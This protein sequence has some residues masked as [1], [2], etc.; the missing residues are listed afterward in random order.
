MSLVSYLSR[1]GKDIIT[2]DVSSSRLTVLGGDVQ[3]TSEKAQSKHIPCQCKQ[4]THKHG[5]KSLVLT[6]C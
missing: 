2:C 3:M 4:E 6:A 1:R 5:A